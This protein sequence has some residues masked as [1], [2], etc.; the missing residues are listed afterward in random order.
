M[1]RIIYYCPIPQMI[2]SLGGSGTYSAG[3]LKNLDLLK[4]PESC[5]LDYLFFG[6]FN[7]QLI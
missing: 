4:S 3:K 5:I 1:M 2:S 6:K 7:E